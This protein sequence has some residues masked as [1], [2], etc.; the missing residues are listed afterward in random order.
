MGIFAYE[1]N[2]KIVTAVASGDRQLAQPYGIRFWVGVSSENRRL[3]PKEARLCDDPE[4]RYIQ[5]W[6]PGRA[7]NDKMALPTGQPFIS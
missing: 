4:G 3:R 6:S 1:V 7:R 2:A 5:V